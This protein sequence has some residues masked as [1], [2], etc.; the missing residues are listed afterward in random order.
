[1]LQNFTDIITYKDVFKMSS[2]EGHVVHVN[3]QLRSKRLMSPAFI[4]KK[5]LN[6][7]IAFCGYV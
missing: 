1:M 3:M 2:C 4:A 5:C 6:V 7:N